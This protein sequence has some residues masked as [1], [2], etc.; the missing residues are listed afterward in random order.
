[1]EEVE[2]PPRWGPRLLF[3]HN[4]VASR[5]APHNSVKSTGVTERHHGDSQLP[6]E[7]EDRCEIHGAEP[8]HDRC[9]EGRSRCADR[10]R[11][12]RPGRIEREMSDVMR[13]DA[14]RAQ[15][16]FTRAFGQLESNRGRH[17]EVEVAGKNIRGRPSIDAV[18]AR[19]E[20]ENLAEL[21]GI[22]HA[23]RREPALDK[24]RV[25]PS[26]LEL[27]PESSPIDLV[28]N[29]RRKRRLD[30]DTEHPRHLDEPAQT[31]GA[32]VVRF[33]SLHL[34][35]RHTEPIRKIALRE[36]RGNARSN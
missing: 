18:D 32:P 30:R 20:I 33:V 16:R 36:A 34:L 11:L 3:E 27:A 25:K 19:R 13:V 29:W 4:G 14:V 7:P 24:C 2:R 5:C 26:T 9:S 31:R 21:A 28:R 35:F 23:P 8:F 10:V 6:C 22:L 12:Q 1:M 15:P 17:L